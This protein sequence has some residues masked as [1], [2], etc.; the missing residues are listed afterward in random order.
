MTAKQ[1]ELGIRVETDVYRGVDRPSVRI[2]LTSTLEP[3]GDSPIGPQEVKA[4]ADALRKMLDIA[5]MMNV[6]ETAFS[7]EQSRRVGSPPSQPRTLEVLQKVYTPRSMAHIDDL[8][9]EGQI[10]E[11]EHKTLAKAVGHAGPEGSS[12]PS[13]SKGTLPKTRPAEELL[14]EFE[15]KDI[16][17]VNRAR[18][19][20]L[21]SYEE[22]ALLKKHFTKT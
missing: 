16:T 7:E 20:R 2:V 15:M 22:W 21:I 11:E 1:K 6:E 3:D 14:K 10:T 5:T 8:L 13:S 19:K 17:D 18:G 12:G 4:A 9:W